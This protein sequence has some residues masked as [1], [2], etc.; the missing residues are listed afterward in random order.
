MKPVAAGYLTGVR[1]ITLCTVRE[2]LFQI[3]KASAPRIRCFVGISIRKLAARERRVEL[4]APAA[5]MNSKRLT[6]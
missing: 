3:L 2:R 6:E 5:Q 4:N 1:M